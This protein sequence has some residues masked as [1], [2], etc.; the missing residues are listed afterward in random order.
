MCLREIAEL[1]FVDPKSSLNIINIINLK[2]T[3]VPAAAADA[4]GGGG[5][6]LLLKITEVILST[7]LSKSS[8]NIIF[9]SQVPTAAAD[10]HGGGGRHQR[11]CGERFWGLLRFR[12]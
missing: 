3:Q 4:H 9:E 8:V 10:A 11:L 5:S 7:K 6:L 12:F 1:S 2:T